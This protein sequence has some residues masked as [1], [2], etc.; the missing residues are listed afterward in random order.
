M[1]RH[2]VP[3]DAM[4][5]HWIHTAAL[6]ERNVNGLSKEEERSVGIVYNTDGSVD[7]R[8]FQCLVCGKVRVKTDLFKHFG[9]HKRH[10]VSAA[11]LKEWCL[12]NDHIL[13]NK[14]A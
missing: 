14:K 6:I 8:R 3:E 1:A 5:T 12:Y 13:L 7:E 11:T 4:M 9:K 2:S 10:K